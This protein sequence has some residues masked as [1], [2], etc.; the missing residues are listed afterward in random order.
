[1]RRDALAGDKKRETLIIDRLMGRGE[2]DEKNG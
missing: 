2:G 1:M